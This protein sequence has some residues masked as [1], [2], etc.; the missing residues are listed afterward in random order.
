[1][2]WNDGVLTFHLLNT[3]PILFELNCNKGA[4]VHQ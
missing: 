2:I 3:F 1:M 4:A